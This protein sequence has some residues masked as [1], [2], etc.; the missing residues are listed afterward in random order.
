MSPVLPAR[1]R[2][3]REYLGFTREDVAGALG[4]APAV[5]E[6]IEAGGTITG[7]QL[8]KL[9]RLYRRPVAWFR[10]ESRFEPG[11]DLLRM[12]E[13]LSEHDRDAVLEF[14]EWLQHAGQPAPR[15]DIKEMTPDA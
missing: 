8:R 11:A 6:R 9:S 7:G 2:D 14:A 3:A 12:T 5:L 4:C 10:G 1:L 13:H 15:I